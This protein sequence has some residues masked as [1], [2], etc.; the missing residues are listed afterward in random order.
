[1]GNNSLSDLYALAMMPIRS[2]IAENT[3]RNAWNHTFRRNLQVWEY[4][5]L[6]NLIASIEASNIRGVQ[7][8]N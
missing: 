6:I 1:M 2:P 7:K 5:G 3:E 4:N 8:P